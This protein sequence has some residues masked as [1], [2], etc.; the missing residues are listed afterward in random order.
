MTPMKKLLALFATAWACVIAHRARS[1]LAIL[2]IVIGIAAVIS[3]MSI[4]KGAEADILSRIQTLGSNLITIRAGAVTVSGVRS[5]AGS[6]TRLTVEDAEAITKQ[7]PYLDAIAPVYNNNRQ[8]VFGNNNTNTQIIG[9]TADYIRIYQLSTLAGSFFSNYD[10]EQGAMVAVLGSDV[11]RML[12]KT[13]DPIGQNIRI[14]NVFVRVAGVLKSKGAGLGS[15][16]D[17]VFIPLT[18]VQKNIAQS[19]TAQGDRVISSISLAVSDENQTDYIIGEISKVLRTRH[20]IAAGAENDF[21]ISSVKDIAETLSETASTLTIFLASIAAISLLV[22]GI[23]VMNIMLVSVLERT[24]EIGL[25]KAMGA[26]EQ[27]IS[28]QFLIEAT[29]L[30]VTGGILG[31]LVGWLVAFGISKLEILNTVVTADTIVLA[32]CVS[33]A[34]GLGFGFYPA[35]RASRLNPIDAL[36]HE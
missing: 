19:R 25:R 21:T 35:W 15:P 32:V 1:V 12:F 7:V 9:T 13:A 4:G 34:I 3:L 24:G 2:G 5:A 18:A 27:E 28:M 36:R 26:T 14:G 33:A 31:V 20:R 22:G 23:G 29:L 16:D 10:Y 6:S 11:A 17:A 8:V 30:T